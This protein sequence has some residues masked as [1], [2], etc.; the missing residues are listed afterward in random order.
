VLEADLMLKISDFSFWTA[1]LPPS[2]S[3][4]L[5]LKLDFQV[6]KVPLM[7]SGRAQAAMK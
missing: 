2:G 6:Q 4:I 5:A 7:Q 1:L 3:L